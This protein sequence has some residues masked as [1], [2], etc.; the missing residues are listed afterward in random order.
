MPLGYKTRTREET[1][2]NAIAP[3]FTCRVCEAPRDH[4]SKTTAPPRQPRSWW[5]YH[6]AL[7]HLCEQLSAKPRVNTLAR[8][9]HEHRH[10]PTRNSQPPRAPQHHRR[11]DSPAWLAMTQHY[12]A[13]RNSPLLKIQ[14]MPRAKLTPSRP[15][16]RMAGPS[17]R[18]T[19]SHPLAGACL[20][21]FNAV[22]SAAFHESPT[23]GSAV[24]MLCRPPTPTSPTR[25]SPAFRPPAA[26]LSSGRASRRAPCVP[27]LA[28]LLPLYAQ[29]WRPPPPH[30][31]REH[32]LHSLAH[33]RPLPPELPRA[34]PIAWL[35]LSATAATAGTG[36]G[37]GASPGAGRLAGSAS[38]SPPERSSPAS[39]P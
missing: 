16:P 20:S 14:Q 5:A 25:L 23:K 1:S 7:A 12:A 29:P 35:A 26:L 19:A 6:T 33:A 37:T 39:P 2:F 3:K 36:T 18:S 30:A 24:R 34:C 13:T 11:Q 8:A 15:P 9:R 10:L 4:R 17:S 32:P 31:C 22:G 28:P 38:C 21:L 27:L